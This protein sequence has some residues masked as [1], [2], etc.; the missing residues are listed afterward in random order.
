MLAVTGQGQVSLQAIGMIASLPST[1]RDAIL[2][3]S[4]GY[5]TRQPASLRVSMTAS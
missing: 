5:F 3:I 2:G 4:I 1:A